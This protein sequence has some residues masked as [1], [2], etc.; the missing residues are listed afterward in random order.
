MRVLH[1][2]GSRFQNIGIILDV[3]AEPTIAGIA[4]GRDEVLE[5]AIAALDGQRLARPNSRR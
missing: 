3:P 5:A 1:G 4:A 2:D